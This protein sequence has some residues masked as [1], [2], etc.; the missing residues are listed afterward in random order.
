MEKLAKRIETMSDLAAYFAETKVAHF[1]A[2]NSSPIIVKVDGAMQFEE[3]E[4]DESMPLPVKLQSCHIGRNL[5]DSNISEE[6]MRDAMPTFCNKPILAYIHEVNGQYEFYN[7]AMH[8]EDDELVYDEYPVGIIPESCNAELVYDKDK[9]KTYVQVNGCLFRDYSKAVEIMEREKECP[10]SV[11][12]AIHELSYNAVEKVLDIEKF[13]FTGVTLL[14]KTPDG[15]KVN[16]G[17][18]GANAKIG[19]FENTETQTIEQKFE[20][21]LIEMREKLEELTAR[22]NKN[23]TQEGGTGEV[24]RFEELLAQYG[25]TVEEVTFEYEG[26]SDEELEQAFAE[27]FADEEPADNPEDG[28][29]DAT[30][31]DGSEGENDDPEGGSFEGD[32]AGEEESGEGDAVVEFTRFQNTESGMI[33]SYSISHE[34]IRSGLYALLAPYEEED[35]TWYWIDKVF[36]DYFVYSNWDGVIYGQKYAVEDDNIKFVDSR[37]SLHLEYLTD[38]ELTELNAMRSNYAELKQFKED[39]L[40]AQAHAEKEAVLADKKYSVLREK[41]EQDH[42][43]N[44]EFAAL[45]ENMDSYSV[46]ELEKEAKVILADHITNGGTFAVM[47]DDVNEEGQKVVNKKFTV[48][49]VKKTVNSK[50]GSLKFN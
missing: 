24:N 22:F 16:P 9:D 7:H 37:Y 26:M 43:K 6:A 39:T 15:K 12:I 19:S 20:Q 41:D 23:T 49:P 33:V 2:E 1:S 40:F 8:L 35:N 44:K 36:D 46:E 42:I 48:N 11:E 10:V 3:Q 29:G 13:H 28:D 34:D 17:M 38:N 32:G 27:A 45:I 18:A 50:Y 21:E 47:A 14:G 25:K 31:G 5:N 4:Y 30:S